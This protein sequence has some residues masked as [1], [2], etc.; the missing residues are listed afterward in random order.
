MHDTVRRKFVR[1]CETFNV[2][3]YDLPDDSTQFES[4]FARLQDQIQE[5]EGLLELTSNELKSYANYFA[6]IHNDEVPYDTIY[7]E[8]YASYLEEIRLFIQIEKAIYYHMNFLEPSGNMMKGV[9]WYNF[10]SY[11]RCPV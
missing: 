3:F 2:A 9:F 8:G 10:T 5:V 7:R 4:V 6:G 11:F 1:I